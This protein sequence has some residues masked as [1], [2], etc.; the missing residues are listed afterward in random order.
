MARVLCVALACLAGGTA[1]AEEVI[2]GWAGPERQPHAQALKQGVE[3]A[4]AE[5]NQRGVQVQG[6][7]LEFKLLAYDD[8]GNPNV[9]GFA[10]QALVTGKAV[11]VVGHYTTETTLA[12][13]QVYAEKGVAELAVFS[14][15]PRLTQMG[16]KNVF[17][18]IGNITDATTYMTAAVNR[19][20]SG[21]RRL[22]IAYNGSIMGA[23]VAD[24]LEQ[25]MRKQGGQLAGRV[26]IS[27]RTS[28]FNAVLK[29]VRDN[30]AD[31]LYFAGIQEQAFAL[32]QRL[33]GANLKVQLMLSGGAFN[34]DFYSGAGGYREGTLLMAHNRPESQLPGFAR[35]EKAYT[36]MFHAPVMPYVANA[37]DAAGMVIEAIRRGN[38]TEPVAISAQLHAMSY[39]GVT[40]R[41]AFDADGRLLN[42]G[43]TLYEVSQK[44]WKVVR[45][46]P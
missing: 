29:T 12:G 18:L 31:L 17:Q 7:R 33:R 22:T 41:I 8:N 43:Y 3:L 2:I 25:E 39:E 10:A 24:A 19:M 4:I 5:A 13:A 27:A 9:S 35:F 36:A 28:D 26:S 38:T 30:K 1:A 34:T 6:R 15:S 16:Y 40:G 21:E 46:F 32:S 23:A 20:G 11:A 14:P 37:Y 44:K 42:P 45:S